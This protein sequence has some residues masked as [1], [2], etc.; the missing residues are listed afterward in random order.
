MVLGPAPA[1]R[2]PPLPC[3]AGVQLGVGEMLASPVQDPQ[4]CTSGSPSLPWAAGV[5][6]VVA[7]GGASGRWKRA[8]APPTLTMGLSKSRALRPLPYPCAILA[9]NSGRTEIIS[10]NCPL[11]G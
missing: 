1:L 3:D 7:A 10:L 5:R 2:Q 6:R 4:V 8:S 9:D 11:D